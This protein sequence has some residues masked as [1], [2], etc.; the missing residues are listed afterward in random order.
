MRLD[1]TKSKEKGLFASSNPMPCFTFPIHIKTLN[2]EFS[3][4]ALLDTRAS[5]CFM[6]KDFA[7][8]HSLELIGKAHPAPME[9][10]DG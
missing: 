10:I 2:C 5:A 7:L 3:S 1:A 4:D 8:K 9:V 6:D